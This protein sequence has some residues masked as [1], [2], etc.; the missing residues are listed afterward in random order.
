MSLF[1]NADS[2]MQIEWTFYWI[3]IWFNY[4]P[5]SELNVLYAWC[6]Y[7]ES[8][9]M[10]DTQWMNVQS[11]QMSSRGDVVRRRLT[12]PADARHNGAD[13]PGRPEEL[14]PSTPTQWRGLANSLSVRLSVCQLSDNPPPSPRSSPVDSVWTMMFL[15]RLSKDF[16]CGCE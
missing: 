9:L 14:P 7:S 4:G 11:I 5:K 6:W 8:W 12:R 3:Q 1:A 13:G 16:H 15:L 10:C 2:D